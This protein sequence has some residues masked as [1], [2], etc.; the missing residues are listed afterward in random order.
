[1]TAN[2]ERRQSPRSTEPQLRLLVIDD[3]ANYRAYVA[4]LTRRLGFWVD[5]AEDGEDALQL[6]THASYDAA[7][8]DQEMPRLKGT[9]LIGW[10]RAIDRTKALYAVMLTAR[11]DIDTK[12]AALDAGFDDFLTKGSAEAEIVAKL[13]AARRVAARQRKM[14]TAVRELYGL[15]TRDDLT[16]V[17][18]RRFFISEVE[19]ML[20]EGTIVNVVLL[21]VDDFKDVNDTHGH[22]A[23]D[24]VLRDVG[25]ALMSNTRPDDIVARFG[26]DEFVVAIPDLDIAVVE[27]IAE[28]L[29][30]AL[31]ARDW[32]GTAGL[33]VS[34]S[35][36]FASSRFLDDPTLAQ[37]LNAAD[38][39][40][41]KNKWIRKHPDL[42]PEL[43]EYPSRER[44]VVE[45]LLNVGG[46]PRQR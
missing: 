3:D 8:I 36:G 21:D 45:R 26:G 46:L 20:A 1:V 28:R 19:R 12:L 16:G 39:D 11:E 30:R 25:T 5:T 7:I 18:N 35:A 27:A 44:D 4:A 33:R 43:Y 9:A 32:G 29:T 24:A 37:L 17:F 31:A 6:L 13:V 42:R 14:D 40:M 15:A 2:T 22:L 34:A 23:G 41:Y 10:L 38:R